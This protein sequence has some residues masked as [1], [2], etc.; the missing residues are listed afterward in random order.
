MLSAKAHASDEGGTDF[1]NLAA[2][3]VDQ[4]DREPFQPG[5]RGRPVG[6]PVCGWPARLESYF[7]PNPTFGVQENLA[8]LR[9]LGA[10]A[11]TLA[12]REGLVWGDT[13]RDAALSLALDVFSWGRV[14]QRD[15]TVRKVHDVFKAALEGVVVDGTP[16]N[17]GWTKVAAIATMHLEESNG[18]HVIWDSRVSNSLVTRLDYVLAQNG[19][20]AI[21]LDLGRLGEVPGR[22]GSRRKLSR[23]LRWPDAYRRWDSQFAATKF[24]QAI[25]DEL[26]DRGIIANG[27]ERWSMRA[28]EMV[29]FMDG[30]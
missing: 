19:V 25:R 4:I 9:P 18:S 20:T 27:A 1:G 7:W 15:I 10:R 11:A 21:P 14:P 12:Q 8:R 16:M 2:K 13:D 6:P 24:V 29:L 23:K 5:Y 22:G 3:I 28:V 30:Y 26:N 17:S